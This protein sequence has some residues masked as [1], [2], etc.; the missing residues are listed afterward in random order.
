MTDKVNKQDA[1][2]LLDLPDHPS[3]KQSLYDIPAGCICMGDGLYG[4]PCSSSTHAVIDRLR[5]V[6]KERDS[7]REELGTLRKALE[8]AN[9]IIEQYPLMV[10]NLISRK[11]V[12]NV[13]HLTCAAEKWLKEY[14]A[15]AKQEVSRG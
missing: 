15:L 6:M 3:G 4:M 10:K 2:D 13:P 9:G 1:P 5:E 8:K 14:A 11:P 12:T 7:A